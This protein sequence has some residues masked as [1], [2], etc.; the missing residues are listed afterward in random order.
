MVVS[1]A[2]MVVDHRQNHLEGIRAVLSVALSPL[3][4]IINLP[5]TTGD[6]ISETFSTRSNLLRQNR[7]LKKENLLLQVRQQKLDSLKA[8]NMRLRNLLDSA[9]KIRDRV[10]IAEVIAVDLDP[11]RHQ[12]LINKG[13]SSGIF[14]GQPVLDASAVM[15]QVT[16]INPFSSTVLLITD[17]S[18]GLPVQVNRN[19]LRTVA[20]GTGHIDRLEL[21][22]LP[23]NADI[24]V[25]DLLVTSGLGGRFPPGYPVAEVTAVTRNPGQPFASVLAQPKA[26]LD[27]AREALLVWTLDSVQSYAPPESATQEATESDKEEPPL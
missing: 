24:K 7:A 12:V 21:P 1:L 20:L 10:L 8:E 3:D 27:Q 25:G 4:V 26:K 9:F 17:A 5:R 15:G 11:Y 6:W 23:N 18:H 14:Q 16:H 2:L 13:S 19:G 22:H